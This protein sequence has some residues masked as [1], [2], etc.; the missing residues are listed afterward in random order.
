[1]GEKDNSTDNWACPF[2]GHG[3]AI[4]I[5]D[6]VLKNDW[7]EILCGCLKCDEMYIRE[8]II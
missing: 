4:I 5:E 3:G 8:Y 2:C 1:M 6:G 7:R